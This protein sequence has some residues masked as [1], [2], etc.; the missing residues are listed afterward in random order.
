VIRAAIADALVAGLDDRYF[1][2]GYPYNPDTIT[3]TTRPVCVWTDSVE[4]GVTFQRVAIAAVVWVLTG[5]Q[6]DSQATDDELEDALADV[7][8]VLDSA[9][10]DGAVFVWK[11]ATRGVLEDTWHGYRV[12]VSAAGTVVPDATPDMMKKE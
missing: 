10:T 2:A 5:R 1:V 9:T 4:R 3:G 12:E 8:G 11:K 6:D 7:L